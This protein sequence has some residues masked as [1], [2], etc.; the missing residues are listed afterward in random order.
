METE[1]ITLIATTLICIV[2]VFHF[3]ISYIS[4]KNRVIENLSNKIEFITEK[5][6]LYE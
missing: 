6:Y 2:V 1:I 5:K 4:Y 3:L